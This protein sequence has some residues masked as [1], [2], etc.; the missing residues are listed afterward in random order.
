MVKSALLATCCGVLLALSGFSA[1][2]AWADGGD[3]SDIYAVYYKNG[4]SYTLVLQSD[5]TPDTR[6]GECDAKQG[7][8][9]TAA[10][11]ETSGAIRRGWSSD[12]D[13]QVTKVIVRDAI[14]PSDTFSWFE[15]MTSCTE[16]DLAKLDTGNVTNMDSMFA[17]CTSLKS[18][19]VSGWDTSK[20]ESM[21]L[22]FWNCSSLESLDVSRWDTSKL[23]SA[24][25][26]FSCCGSLASLDVSRWN[27]KSL[28]DSML[29]FKGC[30]S[31]KTLDVSQWH[32]PALTRAWE[33]FGQCASLENLVATG[34]YAPN[35]KNASAL[36]IECSSLKSV[37]LSSLSMASVDD[38]SN[39]FYGCSSLEQVD[40]SGM[41]TSKAIQNGGLEGFFG[42]CPKLSLVKVGAQTNLRGFFPTPSASSIP[43]ATGRWVNAKGVAFAASAIPGNVAASYAAEGSTAAAALVKRPSSEPVPSPA[44]TKKTSLAKASVSVKAKAWTGK[45]LKPA[46]PTVKV[47]G[48][49]LRAGTDYTWSCRG[50]KAVGSYKV[51][52]TGRGAYAGSKTATFKIVPKGTSVKKLTKAK[53]AFT[54]K[55]KK[56]SKAALKQITGHKVQVS[57]DKKFKK[58]VKTKIVRGASK[59]S[60]KVTKLKSKKTYYVRVCSYKKAGK[61]AVCS[62]WSK[63]QKVK[64]K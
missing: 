19:D 57:T 40:V 6:Y 35:L 21:A 29:M 54:V 3:A 42:N 52:V 50:G 28:K 47:G 15:D 30:R 49:T 53:R 45:T 39:L 23:G 14:K 16:M 11:E 36:L 17:Q 32:A 26:M 24:A 51:T 64:V 31:L 61:S 5:E 9:V 13:S 44:E 34:W 1:H 27:V 20:V 59:T 62:G 46:A 4:G 12:V 37:D 60:L 48:K 38:L 63:A 58:A 25:S 56:P 41:N 18:V 10:V 22:M 55:W 33:M 8:R 2:A 7:G 43:G